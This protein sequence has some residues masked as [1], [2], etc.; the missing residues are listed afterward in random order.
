ME[1]LP[2]ITLKVEWNEHVNEAKYKCQQCPKSY[3]NSWHLARHV[4]TNHTN[5]KPYKCDHCEKAYPH[6][7]SLKYHVDRKKIHPSTS[8]ECPRKAKEL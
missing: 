6:P 1:D 7:E 5:R 3:Q 4:R 8:T 2:K